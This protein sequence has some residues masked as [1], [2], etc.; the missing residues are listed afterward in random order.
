MSFKE[1]RKMKKDK[2]LVCD[3]KKIFLKMF[4]RKFENEFDFTDGHFLNE[5]KTDSN[6]FDR[7]IYVIHDKTE[8]LQF[9]K[10]NK[11]EN[12]VLV[13]LFD[14]QLYNS[15]SFLEEINSLILLDSSKTRTEIV[16]ELKKYFSKP[17]PAL[18]I[19]ES[20]FPTS[21]HLQTQFNGFYKA[22]FF[23]M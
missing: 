13:C 4:K 2:V 15:M 21:N 19:T 20:K 11:K 5:N 6:D 9:L 12:N 10:L 8:L 7:F 14:K 17:D 3:N 23:M 22:L 18:Q 16:K 1:I